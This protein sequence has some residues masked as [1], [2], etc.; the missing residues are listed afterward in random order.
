MPLA[1]TWMDPEIITVGEVS[2]TKKV[3][4]CLISLIYRNQEKMI[5]MNLHRKQKEHIVKGGKRDNQEILDGHV[6][7]YVCVCV[8]VYSLPQ[9]SL[10]CLKWITNEDLLYSTGTLPSI[11]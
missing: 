2:Q 4:Y 11:M 7:M 3:K 8:C 9:P 6:H 10:L 5:Q 1:T